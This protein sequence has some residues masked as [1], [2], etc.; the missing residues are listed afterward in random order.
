MESQQLVDYVEQQM[1]VGHSEPTVREH[2]I[3]YGWNQAA[4]DDAFIKYR[5]HSAAE[6]KA[7][8]AAHRK[9][10]RRKWTVLQ[11][12][13]AGVAAVMA[14]GLVTAGGVAIAKHHSKP[15][16]VAAKPL[17]Y[18]QRQ[19]IDVVNVASAVGQYAFEADALPTMI[20]AASDNAI[21]L[22]GTSCTAVSPVE[23]SLTVYKAAGIKLAPYSPG[24]SAPDK[25]SM[26]LVPGA[27]CASKNALGEANPNPRAMVILYAQSVDASLNQRCVTL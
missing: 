25:Y 6:L 12:A 1:R 21:T 5:R 24:L 10:R 15:P 27:K 23:V 26:Y 7:A 22:C 11:W 4:I 14:V 8:R 19:G 16:L 18:A 2:L 20:T 9:A 13:K 17:T 3:Q